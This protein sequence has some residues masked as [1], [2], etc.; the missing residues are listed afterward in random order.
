[1]ATMTSLLTLGCE[2]F[3]GS[4][5]AG[6]VFR[7]SCRQGLGMGARCDFEQG[8][9]CCCDRIA[10]GPV[11]ITAVKHFPPRLR[12][13]VEIKCRLLTGDDG[14]CEYRGLLRGFRGPLGAVSGDV[15]SSRPRFFAGLS[16]S[17][18]RCVIKLFGKI[19]MG[20][21]ADQSM[22]YRTEVAPS[23]PRQ[24]RFNRIEF[25]GLSVHDVSWPI[26]YHSD[27]LRTAR[28]Y[29]LKSTLVKRKSMREDY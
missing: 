17:P 8:S 20:A 24:W 3:F 26:L 19:K 9:S 1:M 27:K 22:D 29:T 16:R 28:S 18:S 14:G 15:V 12:G 23:P 4:L 7:V 10:K 11:G 25:T 13:C 2:A 5:A 6:L 21:S